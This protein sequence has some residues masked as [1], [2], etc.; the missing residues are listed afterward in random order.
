M[1]LPFSLGC[2]L[3]HIA[4]ASYG[5]LDMYVYQPSRSIFKKKE[6]KRDSGHIMTLENVDEFLTVLQ[7]HPR[8]LALIQPGREMADCDACAAAA[9][10]LTEAGKAVQNLYPPVNF[11]RI[12]AGD[13][14]DELSK[15]WDHKLPVMMLFRN[16]A[17]HYWYGP[18]GF[19]Q[20]F[21]LSDI[22]TEWINEECAGHAMHIADWR[23]EMAFNI[24]EGNIHQADQIPEYNEKDDPMSRK[25]KKLHVEE[26]METYPVTHRHECVVVGVF[27][28]E[29]HPNYKELAMK[30]DAVCTFHYTF[31]RMVPKRYGIKAPSVVVTYIG[32]SGRKVTAIYGGKLH[33]MESLQE[34]VR[35]YRYPLVWRLEGP[36]RFNSFYSDGRPAL[37]LFCDRFHNCDREHKALKDAQ[38]KLKR[39]FLG[40][41]VDSELYWAPSMMAKV[42]VQKSD[43]PALLVAEEM[44][45]KENA[46][47]VFKFS[48]DL[49]NKH[50]IVDWVKD[51][52]KTNEP[53]RA[54]ND[55]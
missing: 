39:R 7:K 50:A 51:Y 32:P 54:R 5:G 49:T 2:L 42:E 38:M 14:A 16:G 13:R 10:Y 17:P 30:G 18:N 26:I 24:K 47:R 44:S 28:N 1:L 40:V 8:V 45:A 52:L 3:I 33:D 35:A 9:P 36:E 21:I 23:Q 53:E 6:R 20:G 34:F 48:G 25:T 41:M 15:R 19:P 12:L 22:L 43:V 37:M 46:K 55:L 31:N 29:T 27:I 4:Y 11:I